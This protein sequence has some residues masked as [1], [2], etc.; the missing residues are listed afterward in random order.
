MKIGIDIRL[1]G[2]NQTGS[3]VVV[4]NLVK[5]MALLESQHSFKLFT[6]VTDREILAKISND[7]GI[8]DKKNFEIVSIKTKNRF[9]WN[10]WALP[11]YLRKNPV[12]VYHTQYITP[13]FV[14]RSI[15]IVTI[16]HDSL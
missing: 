5:Q 3:E 6:E 12:D 16:V 7:L 14:P 2:K 1:I 10:F 9:S 15:K 4:F 11:M 8:A 13:F